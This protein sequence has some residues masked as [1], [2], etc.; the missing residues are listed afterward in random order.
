M[1]PERDLGK[2]PHPLLKMGSIESLQ[3]GE[4]LDL[5][6]MMEVGPDLHPLLEEDTQSPF[7]KDK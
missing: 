1:D 2:D 3:G 7:G 5:H 6:Q 4:I